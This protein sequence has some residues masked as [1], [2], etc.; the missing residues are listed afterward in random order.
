MS[1][2]RASTTLLAQRSVH[3]RIMPRPS[4]VSE[5]REILRVL[6]RFGPMDVYKS[7]RFEYH[8]PMGNIALAIYSHADSAQQALNA[9]P[10]RFALE[11]Y[12]DRAEEAQEGDMME[13]G[14]NEDAD[15]DVNGRDTPAKADDID[16]ILRPSRL[17]NSSVAENA[18]P[19]E[20]KPAPLPF[21]PPADAPKTVSTWF[22]ITVDRSR[23]VHQ[24]YI[25]KQP[26]WARFTPMKSIAQ[27]DLEKKV[28]HWGLSDVSK[29]PPHG[30]RVPNVALRHMS[31]FV[32][33]KMPTIRRIWEETEMES[34]SRRP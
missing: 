30:H 28:P 23:T 13:D 6:Q 29:R 32:E 1:L 9:S 26:Y 22:Q 14:A 18:P 19:S 33:E 8:N 25:E 11:K 24:D 31:R 20:P 12:V 4:S 21:E 2:R 3:L 5:S 17:V 10:I 16:D 7:L 15:A 27:Q 34:E